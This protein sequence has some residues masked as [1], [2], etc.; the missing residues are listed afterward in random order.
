MRALTGG[1]GRGGTAEAVRVTHVGEVPRG[2]GEHGAVPAPGSPRGS[3]TAEVHVVAT[4]GRGG[5]VRTSARHVRALALVGLRRRRRTGVVH[6]HVAGSGS[7]LREGSLVVL[8]WFRRVPVVV[9]VHD[10]VALGATAP[11]RWAA[12]ATLRRARL[13]TVRSADVARHLA[14][15]G[16]PDVEVVAPYVPALA[17]PAEGAREPVVVLAGAMSRRKGVDVLLAA[18]PRV[19]AAVP[20]AR[21]L[22]LGPR[23]DVVPERAAP[24]LPGVEPLGAQPAAVVA[25]TL[26]GARV[27]VLPSRNEH[28]PAFLVEAMAAGCGVVATPVGRVPELL[29]PGADGEVVGELVPVGDAV[30]LADALVRALDADVAAARGDAARCRAHARLGAEGA[31]SR[32]EQIWRQAAVDIGRRRRASSRR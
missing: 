26:S 30:A 15:L 1:R 16:V 20:E 3:A 9:T 29:A 25:R 14:D 18:W 6:V 24:G 12:R 4:Y 19:R 17:A 11:A 5:R 7:R 32:M 21:L 28:V 27:A 23:Y 31:G 8:A 10:R 13:V 22:L 2:A